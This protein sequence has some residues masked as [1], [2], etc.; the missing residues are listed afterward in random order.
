[1]PKK[2]NN[3]DIQVILQYKSGEIEKNVEKSHKKN[4]EKT[5]QE[6]MKI[7]FNSYILSERSFKKD[8]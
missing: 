4:N 1:M 6:L 2:P 7:L 8:K 3:E 5:F